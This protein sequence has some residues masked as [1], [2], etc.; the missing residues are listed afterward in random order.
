MKKKPLVL[1]LG[2]SGAGVGTSLKAFEDLNFLCIDNLPFEM[3]L[4]NLEF[5]YQRSSSYS[6]LSIGLHVRETKE[7]SLLSDKVTRQLFNTKFDLDIVFLKADTDVLASRYLTL[8]RKHPLVGPKTTLANAIEEQGVFFKE[9]K[10][11]SHRAIDTSTLSPHGLLSELE[12]LYGVKAEKRRMNVSIV[13]FGFKRGLVTSV[14]SLF[15]VRCFDN[16]FFDVNLRPKNGKNIEVK[17][18]LKKRKN[19]LEFQDKLE[20]LIEWLLPLYY[21]E[22]KHY[23]KIAIG[24]TGGKHR[25]VFFAEALYQKIKEQDQSKYV[26]NL[27]HRDIDCE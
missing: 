4:P 16:P 17:E 19:V 24:C 15:D 22:G 23:F 25:S 27:S 18:F 12:F 3:L 13:S 21:S 9:Y 8:R 26:V 2:M 14:D 20:K 6:G 11:F 10:S 5:L 7:L 1:I